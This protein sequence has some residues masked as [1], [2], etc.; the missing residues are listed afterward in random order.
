MKDQDLAVVFNLDFIEVYYA[1][2]LGDF[3][4]STQTSI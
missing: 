1:S 3:S 2:A 4:R